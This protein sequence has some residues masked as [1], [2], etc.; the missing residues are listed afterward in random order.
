M[1]EL[2]NQQS[3]DELRVSFLQAKPF[4]HLV[5]DG[6]IP[7]DSLNAVES[8]FDALDNSDLDHH[9]GALQRK[10]GTK[11]NID[12]PALTQQY[13]NFIY[14]GPFLRFLR[15]VTGIANLI[16]DPSLFGGGMHETA[17]GGCFHVHTDFQ[18][19]PRTGLD[20]RLVLITYLNHDWQESFGGALELWQ[21]N[22]PRC[23]VSIVPEFGR[24]ILMAV[25]AQ[26]AH[27]HPQPVVA[28]DGKGRRSVLAY[29]YT[30][31]RDD[32]VGDPGVSPKYKALTTEFLYHPKMRPRELFELIVRQ[33]VPPIVLKALS[34]ANWKFLGRR[35][36]QER[37]SRRRD[38]AGDRAD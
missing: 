26:S 10:A 1:F 35:E 23:V 31:G 29:Y 33:T 38:R 9:L 5:L 13:F 32:L 4:P 19:Q 21:Q 15:S 18:K 22:P 14:S 8:E 12:L 24:S 28:P 11:T 2:N 6:L 37:V 36:N 20:N 34:F 7:E 25:S 30:N 17:H 27:G 3:V 16:P